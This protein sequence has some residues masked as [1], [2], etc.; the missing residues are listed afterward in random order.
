MTEPGGDPEVASACERYEREAAELERTL[1]RRDASRGEETRLEWEAVDSTAREL[2]TRLANVLRETA[3]P[4]LQYEPGAKWRSAL[5]G[6]MLGAWA[7]ALPAQVPTEG[8]LC[9]SVVVFGLVFA[10][11][12]FSR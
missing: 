2:E 6:L 3:F 1:A 10:V 8:V 11:R 7:V 4:P 9:L 5:V 12:A